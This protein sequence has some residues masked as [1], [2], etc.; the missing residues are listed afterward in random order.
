[1]QCTFDGEEEVVSVC[2]RSG[3]WGGGGPA[4]VAVRE[5]QGIEASASGGGPA[6]VGCEGGSSIEFAGRFGVRRR[7]L[8]LPSSSSLSSVHPVLTSLS[9]T[10]TLLTGGT[11]DRLLAMPLCTSSHS[12]C[13]HHLTIHTSM[14]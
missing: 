14:T 1:M 8:P 10:V 2:L 9:A 4:E 6:D 3:D 5:G 7:C 13:L 12:R 11:C